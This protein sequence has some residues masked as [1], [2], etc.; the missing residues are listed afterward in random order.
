MDFFNGLG[1]T[2]G[3][4]A[5]Q[6][7]ERSGE[8]LEAGRLNIEIFKEED[9]I[10]RISRKIGELIYSA[11]DRGEKYTGKADKLCAEISERKKKIEMLK[12]KIRDTKKTE[13]HSQA[14]SNDETHPT[15]PDISYYTAMEKM[16]DQKNGSPGSEL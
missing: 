15:E 8:L 12:S 5:K 16:N 11:Y 6:V 3:E 2:L 1:K 7:E 10:R 9:A 4:V 13:E 14:D